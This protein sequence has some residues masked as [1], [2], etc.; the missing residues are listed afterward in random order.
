M[1]LN[2]IAKK[3]FYSVLIFMYVFM[4]KI[5]GPIDSSIF[6]GFVLALLVLNNRQFQK[7]V[8]QIILSDAFCGLFLT[9]VLLCLWIGIVTVINRTLDFS[10]VKT[11][12]HVFIQII[13]G[14]FVYCYLYSKGE[15]RNIVNYLI[16]AFILQTLVEWLGLISPAFK[17]FI[18]STKSAQT[19]R[20][21]N[22]YGGIRGLSLAGSSF[23]GLAISFG[24]VY[25]LY[26]S[27]YNT[28]FGKHSIA[29]FLC[30]LFLISG[31]FFAGRTGLVGL[32]FACIIPVARFLSGK[33]KLNIKSTITILLILLVGFAIFALIA[34]EFR[35]ANMLFK[36]IGHLYDYVFEAFIS[37]FNGKGLS[38]TS[39][40][41]LFGEM[42]FKI[43]FKTLIVGDGYYTDPITGSYYMNTDSGYMR[44]ILYLGLPGL[45]LMFVFQHYIFKLGHLEKKTKYLCWIFLIILQIKGET[46]GFS[47]ILQSTILLSVLQ[48][49]QTKGL[50]EKANLKSVQTYQLRNQE[51]LEA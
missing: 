9:F 18:Y 12:L 2:S 48:N 45:V 42:Y 13:I 41:E 40:S 51:V 23:F 1:Q 39:T 32:L 27:P 10:F 19:I 46:I 28:L 16:V 36:R 22:Q 3:T 24:L 14:I 20:I 17:S 6:V 34:H 25:I 21:A 50:L 33:T 4:F 5:I 49:S 29:K 38:T 35:D 37:L 43:P 31:T 15:A 26:L 30:L 11:W 47:M 7:R 8:K 44:V